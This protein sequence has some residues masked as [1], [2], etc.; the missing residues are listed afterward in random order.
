VTSEVH[1]LPDGRAVYREVANEFV[2]VAREAVLNK[3][4]FTVVLAEGSTPAALFSLLATDPVLRRRIPWGKCCFFW[5]DERH[6]GTEH[7]ASNFRSCH[8]LI[9]CF[10]VWVRT[11]TL[12][13]SFPNQRHS[14]KRG[15][16]LPRIGCISSAVIGSP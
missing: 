13:R 2:R 12:R 9:S 1:V 6:V 4:Q 8:G 10:L 11:V 3:G 16:W 15:K 5:G 7:S 14:S